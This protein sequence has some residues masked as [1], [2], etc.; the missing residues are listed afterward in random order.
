MPQ[1]PRTPQKGGR[2]GVL[3]HPRQMR[4]YQHLVGEGLRD[5]GTG[6]CPLDQPCHADALLE[7]ANR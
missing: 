6:E 2:D 1:L 7:W 4:Q 5:A 3:R